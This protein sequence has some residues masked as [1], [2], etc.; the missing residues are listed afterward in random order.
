MNKKERERESGG[1]EIEWWGAWRIEREAWRVFNESHRVF[2]TDFQEDNRGKRFS[3]KRATFNVSLLFFYFLFF[4]PLSLFLFLMFSFSLLWLPSIIIAM[5]RNW[6][7]QVAALALWY[8]FVCS[9]KQ[10]RWNRELSMN[11]S[12][13]SSTL[14]LQFQSIR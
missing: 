9:D 7:W 6:N 10:A 13:S 3:G 2:I 14:T 5:I 1:W 11:F 12:F 4:F 8:D